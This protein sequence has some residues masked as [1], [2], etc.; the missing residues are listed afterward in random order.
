MHHAQLQSADGLVELVHKRQT[1]F[2]QLSSIWTSCD[3][4]KALEE[5][6]STFTTGMKRRSI[7]GPWSGCGPCY[8]IPAI[9]YSKWSLVTVAALM[10]TV[11]FFL[12]NILFLLQTKDS[13]LKLKLSVFFRFSNLLIMKGPLFVPPG[14]WISYVLLTSYLNKGMYIRYFVE[15]WHWVEHKTP[16]SGSA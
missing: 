1:M 6:F 13:R 16:L 14:R 5:S 2:N 9:D 4:T 11:F 12:Q 8:Q 10:L 7:S 15:N 3:S